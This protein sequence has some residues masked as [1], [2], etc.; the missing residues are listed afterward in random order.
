MLN[1]LLKARDL[2][3]LRSRE[4]MLELLLREE[5]GFL[6]PKPD[7]L[8]WSVEENI[9]KNFC[10]GKAELS[11]VTLTAEFGEKSFSFPIYA[12]LP[13]KPGKYPFFV[14]INF[15]PDVPDRYQPTEE[16]ID[17]GYAAL[18]FCYQDVT[19]DDGNFEDGLAGVLFEKGKRRPADPGKIA[20]WAWAAHRVLD[21]AETLDC[22]DRSRATVCGHSRL[23]KTALLAA[24]T[25][26]RFYCGHS[27]DSGCCGAALSRGKGG[28]SLAAIC[29]RFPY[30]FCENFYRYADHE[31]Q[32]PFD[33]H[34]LIAS[35]APRLAH[36]SSAFED[37]WADPDSEYLAC[38]AA[39][40]DFVCEDRLPRVGDVFHSGKIGYDL[41]AGKHYFSREDWLHLMEFLKKHA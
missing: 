21:Y 26:D 25:D 3:A 17:H 6:P 20:M 14:H 13:A 31:G 8:S 41:R 1:E 18:S 35:I 30:W 4:E 10:A 38:V 19:A 37:T 32:M 29:Q 34:Y 27:N 5:Y 16:L 40:G 2:P 7:R 36:V 22:L 24:A 23:G 15:R 9:V 39:N 33:Q 28:E 11:R 12:T